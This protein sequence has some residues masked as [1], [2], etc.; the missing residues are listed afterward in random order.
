MSANLDVI[1]ADTTRM[2]TTVQ[3]LNPFV[4]ANLKTLAGVVDEVKF[5]KT[6]GILQKPAPVVG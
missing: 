3:D 1:H 5:L 2:R 6:R 4:T